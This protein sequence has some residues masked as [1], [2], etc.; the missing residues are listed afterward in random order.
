MKL[1]ILNKSLYADY[2]NFLISCDH[3]LFYYS[4]QYKDFLEDLLECESKY[5]LA[6]DGDKIL[7]V[8]PL[9]I[10]EGS[11]GTVIN[12]LPYYGSNGGIISHSSKASQ[13]L[14][15]QY[16]NII[17]QPDIL[18]STIVENPLNSYVSDIK[19]NSMD[20]RIGQFTTIKCAQNFE[21]E[22]FKIISGNKRNEIRR[23]Q[24]HG[25][26]V[27]EENDQLDF[28]RLT[29]Q[30]E[31][32]EKNRRYKKNNFFNKIDHYF[33]AG[34]DYKIFIARL[35]GEPIAGLLMFYFNKVA[36]YFTPVVLADARIYQPMSL[37]LY[38]VFL[39]AMQH[40]YELI[41]WGGTWLSQEGVY[42]FK[43]QMGAQDKPYSYYTQIN[44][45]DILKVDSTEILSTYPDF[46]VFNFNNPE[47]IK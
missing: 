2:K 3:S 5:L 11:F 40:G 23:A 21:E 19:Y 14:T 6:Y 9:M 10:Q 13:Y 36:E 12:S 25:V 7:G 20:K 37:I 35:D 43:K 42:R 22:T 33:S 46:Y 44:N 45:P 32:Q 8:L 4:V 28:I 18:S 30:N 16:N 31:M 27:A 24:K 47:I 29:H 17:S 38:H 1:E 41:N 26:Q 39:D 15:A 34:K